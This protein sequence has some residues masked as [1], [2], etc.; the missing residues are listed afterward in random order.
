MVSAEKKASYG[1][2][3]FC[4]LALALLGT[5]PLAVVLIGRQGASQQRFSEKSMEGHASNYS[6]IKHKSIMKENSETPQRTGKSGKV[7]RLC[8][9]QFSCPG[10]HRVCI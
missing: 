6:L 5:L 4:W 3:A 8:E 10:T 2:E 9:A 1:L 7:V